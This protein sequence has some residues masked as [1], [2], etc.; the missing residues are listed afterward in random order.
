MDYSIPTTFRLYLDKLLSEAHSAP[1]PEAL[2]E[3]MMQDLYGRL[4]NH[5]M[6]SYMQALPDEHAVA[7]DELMQTDPSQE[8]IEHFFAAHIP[9]IADVSA[10]ALLEFRDVYLGA[11][12]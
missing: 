9:A 12:K 2:R 3:K 5:L 8:D 6:L 4:Q 10:R 7:Y 11:S 1:L